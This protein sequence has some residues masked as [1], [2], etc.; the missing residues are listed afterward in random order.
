MLVGSFTEEEIKLA[1][2]ECGSEK[3]L[4]PNG[5]NFKFIKQ[6]WQILKPDFLR[7]LDKFHA[8]GIFPKGGNASF[9]ALI[10]KVPDPQ[11]LNEY[12][13][14]SLIGC[15][16]KIVAKLLANRLKRILPLIID[17]R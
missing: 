5:I 17:E 14:I 16:F 13:P 8:N 3:S 4:G 12:R 11:S 10:P 9:I 15:V 6:F 2:W 7:F 1:V